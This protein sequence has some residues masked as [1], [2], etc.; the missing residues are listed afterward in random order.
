MKIAKLAAIALLV[1]CTATPTLQQPLKPHFDSMS[2]AI[3]GAARST[4]L[5]SKQTQLERLSLIDSAQAVLRRSG[6]QDQVSLQVVIRKPNYQLQQ[7]ELERIHNLTASVSGPGIP[8]TIWNLGGHVNVAEAGPTNLQIQQVPRGQNR[9]VTV[10]GYDLLNDS[11][12]ALPGAQL[13]AIYSSPPDSTEVTLIFT[14]RSTIEAE[15]LE[16]LQA[17]A[18]E[19]SELESLVNNLDTQGLSDFLDAVV[20]GNHPVGG[21]VY[22]VHP[23][24]LDPAAIADE[25]INGEGQIPSHTAGD[26][27]PSQWLD[28][29]A[30][31]NLV[32]QTPQKIPFTHSNIRVQITDPASNPMVISNG[33]DTA[34]LPQII[35]GDWN[36][37]VHID[38]PNGG[39][40]TRGQVSVD[41]NG[42]VTL[43]AGTAANPLILPPVVQSLSAVQGAAGTQITLTG[44]GFDAASPEQ[45]LVRFGDQ[46]AHVVMATA[47]SLVVEVPGG[48]EGQVP[49]TVTN[50]NQTSNFASFDINRAVTAIDKDGMRS[51]QSLTLTV[52]GYDP[53]ADNPTVTFSGGVTGTV[54]GT[55]PD[56]I[57]VTVPP[58]AQSGPVTVT[59]SGTQLKLKNSGP[60]V[61]NGNGD[62]DPL[63]IELEDASGNRLDL[64]SQTLIWQI[65]DQTLIDLGSSSLADG[66]LERDILSKLPEGHTQIQVSLQSDPTVKTYVD[67]YVSS[68]Q[69][70]TH[71]SLSN[72]GPV[73]LTGSGDEGA[74]SLELEDSNGDR[75]DLSD[76]ELVWQVGDQ[77]LIDVQPGSLNNGVLISD[78]LSKLP[79]GT[80]RI[81][82]FLKDD[83][84][85]R[86]DVDVLV[87]ADPSTSALQSPEV[88]V[89]EP[90]ITTMGPESGGPGTEI[91]LQ[92]YNLDTATG[93]TVNGVTV[94]SGDIDVVDAET[95]KFTVPPGAST[96]PVVVTTPEGDATSPEDLQV[97]LEVVSLSEPGG[98]PGDSVTIKVSG[99]DPSQV[100]TTVS[101]S[102]GNGGLIPVETYGATTSD[103]ITVT[104]PAGAKTGTLTLEP[105][106]LQTL[107]SPQYLV[108]EPSIVSITTP[109]PAQGQS[110]DGP[111]LANQQIEI[112]GI[113]LD[114]ATTVYFNDQPIA[115]TVSPTDPNTLLVTLPAN[116]TTSD[117]KV[118]TPT[119]QTSAEVAVM[120]PPVITNVAPTGPNG[121]TTELT[122]TGAHF[123]T[124]TAI[125][126]N[127]E[128]LDPSDYTIV[129]DNTLVL[130]NTPDNPVISNVTVTNPAGTALSSLTYKDLVNFVGNSVNAPNTEVNFTT[131][132]QPHGIN[133]DYDGNIYIADL[134]HR[135]FKFNSDGQMQWVSGSTSDT[136]L[137]YTGVTLANAHFNSP[138]DV[139]NDADGN[140]YVTDTSNHAIRKITPDGMVY[141]LARVPGPEGIEVAPNGKLYA[142]LNDPPN[143]N[144]SANFSYI[145]EI[146]NLDVIPS[147]AELQAYDESDAINTMTSNATIISGGASSSGGASGDVSPVSAAQYEHLEGLGVDG[148]GN[149]YVADVGA[150]QIRKIN[151]VNDT[152]SVLMTITTDTINVP[153]PFNYPGIGDLPT[154]VSLHEIRVDPLGNVFV[155]TYALMIYGGNY[156]YY[157]GGAN[158]Y[159]IEPNGNFH[160]IVGNETWDLTDG[161]P[162]TDAAFKSP[163]GI[164]FAPDG[165]L[166][167]ADTYWGIRKIERYFPANYYG[168]P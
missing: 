93:V 73:H 62:S 47:T 111:F 23:T 48:V 129:D 154:E 12:E 158:L 156:Y 32:V 97:P 70:S 18:A 136:T 146:S 127:D 139:A 138:E 25:I 164:D 135:I 63:L 26:P 6:S 151:P 13:K 91:T 90:V 168:N 162:L 103:S 161:A 125:T 39:V 112:Q 107:T 150:N 101:F 163:R 50:R 52:S 120:V 22:D 44:D 68:A 119:G 45:N 69:A 104:V 140:I 64:A 59:P 3:K 56:T 82:V 65:G 123:S 130:H 36:A 49:V 131:T 76:Y 33:G 5:A 1:S 4:Y 141:T 159:Q 143:P 121:S 95:I 38:A 166:F 109:N 155:P 57:T 7:L 142:T 153:N 116:A 2:S 42:Q 54:T 118:V 14:W 88:V 99:Y 41:A 96:G 67:V 11:S 51:G 86:T 147:E 115:F 37:I 149:I 15:V 29:M 126:V 134:N 66:V 78:V 77:E 144:G 30:D 108:D 117:I 137:D 9:V 85:V 114:D 61:L 80:T 157:S 27:V 160:R 58:G 106:G 102:D 113:N 89:N 84:T 87:N 35:P 28:A 20:Y 17:A 145:V 122:L 79:Q 16:A 10:Q 132:W 128:V 40:Q 60:I 92:G 43:S 75:L 152:V 124:A 55:T 165:T 105:N 94:P 83:P 72:S 8:E 19:N 21:S 167:V 100:N 34:S 81:Q 110:A 148:Q 98:R 74:V 53:S 46:T 133:V 31:L 24:R 71:L